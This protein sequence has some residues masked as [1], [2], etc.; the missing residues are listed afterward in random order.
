[1][2]TC[3]WVPEEARWEKLLAAASQPDI[4]KRIDDSLVGPPGAV[5][6]PQPCAGKPLEVLRARATDKRSRLTKWH[7]SDFLCRY[8]H[9]STHI[10]AHP[11]ARR[12]AVIARTARI[13]GQSDRSGQPLHTREVA[14][15]KPAAPMTRKPCPMR[16][17]GC[18]EALPDLHAP[19]PGARTVDDAAH[20]ARCPR[21]EG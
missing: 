1:V 10:R 19:S 13:S 4:A 20:N 11:I 5:E 12:S 9:R 17:W 15:S 18:V 3:F 2:R 7:N 6:A 14:G 8:P 21:H 16:V